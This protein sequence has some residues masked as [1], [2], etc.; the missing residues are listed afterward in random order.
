MISEAASPES[1]VLAF[2]RAWDRLDLDAIIGMLADD[3]VYH[4]MPLEPL[5][6]RVA[7]ASYLRSV[8]P[9]ESCSW[10]VLALAV[11]GCSV[12]TERLDTLSVKGKKILLPVMGIFE[13]ENGLIHGWRDYF[14]LASYRAQWPAEVIQ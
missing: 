7:V 6:G 4:N 3:V 1:V 2:A 10:Q 9:I 12:L 5:Y 8:G 14:D 13:V 11:T